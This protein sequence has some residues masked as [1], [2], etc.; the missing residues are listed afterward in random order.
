MIDDI[1]ALVILP[2]L[3]VAARIADV[4]LQTL[5][6]IFTS[7]DKIKIAPIIGFFEVF[8]WLLAIGQLFD[9]LTNILYYAAYASGFAIGN[10]AGIYIDR[11]LSIG[12]LNLQ[13]I[14]GEQPDRLLKSLKEAG[15]GLTVLTA[16]G[17]RNILVQLVI[18]RKNLK[19]V[20]AIIEKH[21]KNAFVTMQQVHSVKGGV[22]P[23]PI[24]RKMNYMKLRKTR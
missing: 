8:I 15:Y 18:R 6:I 21:Y 2:L 9:N 7:R 5:R 22:F 11:K 14:V 16:Q 4:S 1:Y 20:S 13:L 12:L 17:Y 10:F 24:R 3:I 19:E 23:P